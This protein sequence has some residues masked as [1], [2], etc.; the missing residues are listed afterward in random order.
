MNFRNSSKRGGGVIFNPKIYFADLGP[1]FMFFSDVSE[2]KLQYNLFMV[3][4]KPVLNLICIGGGGGDRKQTTAG[5][6]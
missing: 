5:R 3:L 1:L 6:V 2:Q 4:L